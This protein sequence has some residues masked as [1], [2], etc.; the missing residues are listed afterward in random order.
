MD[1]ELNFDTYQEAAKKTAVYPCVG[2]NYIYPC[3]GLAGE[4]GE[5]LNKIKKIQRDQDN[6][7]STITIGELAYEIGDILWYIATLC[8]ELKIGLGE[9]AHTNLIK[10]QHRMQKGML[11]GAGDYR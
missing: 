6:K 5:L 9:V 8:S 1:K 4:V 11:H 10:L 2:N 7:L 3:L